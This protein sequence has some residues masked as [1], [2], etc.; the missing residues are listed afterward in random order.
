M[1][2]LSTRSP[3]DLG[4]RHCLQTAGKL[5]EQYYESFGFA[6]S[7]KLEELGFTRLHKLLLGIIPGSVQSELQFSQAVLNSSDSKGATALLWA[8]QLK[9]I[10]AT[11]QLLDAGAVPN[12]A[13]NMG[14]TPLHYAWALPFE[15]YDA[16]LERGADP[17]A[18]DSYQETPL[19]HV[20]RSTPDVRYLRALLSRGVDAGPAELNGWTPLHWAVRYD[21][22]KHVKELISHGADVNAPTFIGCTPLFFAVRY[23]SHECLK[24]LLDAGA[25]CGSVSRQ[26]D[27]VLH[28]AAAFSDRKSMELLLPSLNHDIDVHTKSHAW[29]KYEG[30]ATALQL[31]KYAHQGPCDSLFELF[32]ALVDRARAPMQ[33]SA[34][35]HAA[36]REAPRVKYSD[37]GRDILAEGGIEKSMPGAWAD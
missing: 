6:Q 36:S 24:Q 19:H 13:D 30:G 8:V 22:S 12:L 10:D 25:I 9:N 15:L 4:L 34:S 20:C 16:L 23:N 21:R 33:T 3:R 31:F 1:L 7:P 2:T 32:M 14:S 11:R 17:E 5:T 26:G 27:T 28:Y 37:L 35:A 18:R 29:Q